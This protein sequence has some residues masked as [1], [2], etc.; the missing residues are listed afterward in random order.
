[1]SQPEESL[2]PAIR[3]AAHGLLQQQA[4]VTCGSIARLGRWERPVTFRALASDPALVREE[5]ADAP[6][7]V[8]K[9][10]SRL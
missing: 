4:E 5:R 1:M 9:L 2:Y 6:S 10:R 3:A 7:A 8:F